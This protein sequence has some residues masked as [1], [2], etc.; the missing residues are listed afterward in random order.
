MHLKSD[1][2]L[3]HRDVVTRFVKEIHRSTGHYGSLCLLTSI[4][5]VVVCRCPFEMPKKD[6][7]V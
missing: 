2:L 1:E 5:H 7:Q 3:A 6:L 4:V